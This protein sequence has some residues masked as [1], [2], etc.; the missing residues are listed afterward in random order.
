MNRIM[1]VKP[2]GRVAR[3]AHSLD[4]VEIKSLTPTEVELV[5][6]NFSIVATTEH[7]GSL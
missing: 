1:S 5:F 4:L 3:E 7:T 6:K 2:S